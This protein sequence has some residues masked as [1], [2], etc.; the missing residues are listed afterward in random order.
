MRRLLN[1]ISTAILLGGI[2]Q[3]AS[4]QAIVQNQ[5]KLW[6]YEDKDGISILECK[7]KEIY[8]EEDGE[9]IFAKNSSDKWGIYDLDGNKIV[10]HKYNV[11]QFE[12]CDGLRYVKKDNKW[13]FIDEKGNVVV[14]LQY[15]D[16]RTFSDGL[17][18]VKKGKKWGYIDTKGD[19]A[20][21]FKYKEAYTFYNGI[22]KVGRQG[23][24]GWIPATIACP[25]FILLTCLLMPIEV[26]Y[27][28]ID[29]SGTKVTPL[30]YRDISEKFD[31]Y[32][33]ARANK[34]NNSKKAFYIDKNN[35]KYKDYNSALIAQGIDPD[36]L[37]EEKKEREK[38]GLVKS[39]YYTGPEPTFV[40]TNTQ[41]KQHQFT[42][43]YQQQ[44]TQQ[45]Q[46]YQQQTNYNVSNNA[47]ASNVTLRNSDVD[48]NIPK[49]T[50]ST[51][52]TFAVIIANEDYKR[53]S[54]VEYAIADGEAFKEYCI[55][56]LGLPETNVHLVTNAG[57]GD[58]KH[59]VSWMTRLGNVYGG[60]AKL[61]FYYAG[62]G[63]PDESSL[64]AYLL[65]VDGYGTD[66]TTGYKLTDLYNQLAAIPSKSTI[67]LLDA[68]F[69]GAERSGKMMASS[70]GVA[71]KAKPATPKGNMVVLTAASG[72][73]TAH[74]YRDKGHG[75]FTYF[76]LKKLKETN[77]NATLGE[78]YDYIKTGVAR[79]AV[80]NDL[81]D[82]SPSAIP[83]A[84]MANTWKNITLY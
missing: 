7:F 34:S 11:I 78:L 42:Q 36:N 58:M 16:A 2:A 68:C 41:Q 4:A 65:P 57:L 60:D 28:Y 83:A 74:P 82:Q 81:K 18:A 3:D 40:A 21:P 72:D 55:K 20:L 76:L 32:G 17:A 67:V 73:E 56:T 50:R 84:S 75:M 14:S 26:R 12:L 31:K 43:Q 37:P 13:G 6:G 5:Y 54:K 19:I 25:T 10:G 80:I 33:I 30:K 45:R 49:T 15:D 27:G 69:S 9:Y 38:K 59:E 77:G 52:N 44:Q 22:A 62:H 79:T 48:I 35:V 66:I 51:E 63:I 47:V 71:L 23:G 39:V 1:L 29:K 24:Y 64:S 8:A 46:Q 70:R 61:I 53:E